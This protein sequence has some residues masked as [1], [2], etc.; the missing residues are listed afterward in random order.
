[1]IPLAI[2]KK[3]RLVRRV[4]RLII[5]R[6]KEVFVIKTSV[7]KHRAS[8]TGLET[9]TL[10]LVSFAVAVAYSWSADDTALHAIDDVVIMSSDRKCHCKSLRYEGKISWTC[11]SANDV[12]S[13]RSTV[14]PSTT[15]KHTLM[16]R[17]PIWRWN[18]ITLSKP[19]GCLFA[20]LSCRK[21]RGL[22]RGV[23]V[24]CIKNL[25]IKFGPVPVFIK[26]SDCFVLCV[27]RLSLQTF[28]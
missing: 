5:R 15:P 19:I 25:L 22:T 8:V 4:F 14:M 21:S 26:R 3:A 16:R 12:P 18:W 28:L 20:F 2:R 9:T 13:R 6:S 23:Q 10:W 7:C 24:R 17:S 1:M 27:Y 11:W